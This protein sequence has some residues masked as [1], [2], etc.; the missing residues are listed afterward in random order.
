M[1]APVLS[2]KHKTGSSAE[3]EEGAEIG[4]LSEKHWD[5]IR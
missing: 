1:L 3:S 5:V 4:D 2:G